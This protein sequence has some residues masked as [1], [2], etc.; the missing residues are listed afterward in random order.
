MECQTGPTGHTQWEPCSFRGIV[1]TL[2]R[3][4]DTTRIHANVIRPVAGHAL[5]RIFRDVHLQLVDLIGIEDKAGFLIEF[6]ATAILDRFMRVSEL[7]P[8]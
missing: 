2:D 6:S 3:A 1:V 8:P 4:K 5:T 7:P